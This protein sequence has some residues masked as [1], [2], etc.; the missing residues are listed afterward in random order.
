M[1]EKGEA[2]TDKDFKL[3]DDTFVVRQC[4]G[5]F[6]CPE[7]GTEFVLTHT[8]VDGIVRLTCVNGDFPGLVDN[9]GFF[10]ADG[11]TLTAVFVY[12]S[13]EQGVARFIFE[14]DG[15]K[16]SFTA[17][18]EP[19]RSAFPAMAGRLPRRAA[20]VVAAAVAAAAVP[21]RNARGACAQL[22]SRRA[23]SRTAEAPRGASVN[24]TARLSGAGACVVGLLARTRA[25]ERIVRTRVTG[26]RGFVR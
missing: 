8:G 11:N 22:G 26:S 10:T 14:R 23:S 24:L 5:G 16:I 7:V 13:G 12:D 18:I 21:A 25:R 1:T 17:T 20:A 9:H 2:M 3:A 6:M 19:C 4:E 15:D